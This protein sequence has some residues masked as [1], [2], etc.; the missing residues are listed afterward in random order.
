VRGVALPRLLFNYRIRPQSMARQFTPAVC[1]HLYRRIIHKSPNLYRR[2]GP[3]LVGLFAEN[4]HGAQAPSPTALSPAHAALFDPAPPRLD[5]LE[6]DLE[7][8][9]SRDRLS[10]AL[11]GQVR[12]DDAAWSYVAARHLLAL[13]LAP[14][15]AAQLLY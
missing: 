7:L 13:N 11:A 4:G 12:S 1:A 5:L 2:Y 3:E 15:Y 14:A 8:Q 10:Q 6:Q 9:A